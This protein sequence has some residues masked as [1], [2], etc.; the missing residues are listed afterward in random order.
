M[1]RHT[2]RKKSQDAASSMEDA[3]TDIV[4]TSGVETLCVCTEETAEFY[5]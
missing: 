5:A 1:A 4:Y 2:H 3:I